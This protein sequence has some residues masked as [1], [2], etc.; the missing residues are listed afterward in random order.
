MFLLGYGEFLLTRLHGTMHL[1]WRTS[2]L[3]GTS[4]F[5][6]RGER[7]STSPWLFGYRCSFVGYQDTLYVHSLRQFYKALSQANNLVLSRKES[8]GEDVPH[9][10]SIAGLQLL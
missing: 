4:L 3:P 7:T 6:T 9:S 1:W 5:R 10:L 2:S 8:K